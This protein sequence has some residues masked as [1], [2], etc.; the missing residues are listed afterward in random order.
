MNANTGKTPDKDEMDA[1]KAQVIEIREEGMSWEAIK[2]ESGIPPGT[3]S[4][5]LEGKYTGDDAKVAMRVRGWLESRERNRL[6]M[7][8]LPEVPDFRMTPTAG[9]AID[10]LELTHLVNDMLVIGMAPGL[11]KTSA[12]I[13]YAATR[14]QV[15]VSTMSPAT[16]GVN[17][18]LA[19]VCESVGE[20]DCKGTPAVLSQRVVKRV[21]NRKILLI[22]DEAQH[23]SEQALEQLRAI[24][25][26]TGIAIALVGNEDLYAML[27]GTGRSNSF[28]QLTSR[29]GTRIKQSVPVRGDIDVVANAWKIEG[30]AERDFLSKIGMFPGALRG[31]TK[32]LLKAGLLA[33]REE[34]SIKLKHIQ[35]AWS[36]VG[37]GSGD[38]S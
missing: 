10:A 22:V 13:Q 3:F 35:A 6:L 33:A 28:G 30:Q 32:T 26:E 29:I 24:H 19:V 38:V 37:S 7:A 23:L 14:P 8:Q 34:S 12:I 18:M 17:T 9:K 2:S 21:Q 16:R 15:F 25:D 1:L 20:T 5:W 36:R 31:V 27:D 11:G 4:P